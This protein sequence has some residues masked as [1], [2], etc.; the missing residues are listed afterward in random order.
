MKI[1]VRKIVHYVG[2]AIKM[3]FVALFCVSYIA[4]YLL[5]LASAVV[6][7]A[8]DEPDVKGPLISLMDCLRDISDEL[9]KTI[10]SID[11]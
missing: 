3:P 7:V 9:E 2:V 10:F 4:L 1:I 6:R 5:Q 8:F 11:F